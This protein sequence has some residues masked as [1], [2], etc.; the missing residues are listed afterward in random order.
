MTSWIYDVLLPNLFLGSWQT[1]ERKTVQQIDEFSKQCPKRLKT[2]KNIEWWNKNLT[3]WSRNNLRNGKV[4]HNQDQTHKPSQNQFEEYTYAF[5]Q[6]IVNRESVLHENPQLKFPHGYFLKGL[7]E[8]VSE[9]S[10]NTGR[11]GIGSQPCLSQNMVIAPVSLSW[12]WK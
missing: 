5:L 4:R 9:K 10:I 3:L 7:R 2:P 1:N 12:Q 6:R 8:N 11:P